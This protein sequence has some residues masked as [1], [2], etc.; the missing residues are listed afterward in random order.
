MTDACAF[1]QHLKTYF[2]PRY[3]W[4]ALY[5]WGCP[6]VVVAVTLIMQA[7]VLMLFPSLRSTRLDDSIAYLRITE[8]IKV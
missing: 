4:Y 1:L 2:R 5:A 3:K 7:S 6:L 8:L